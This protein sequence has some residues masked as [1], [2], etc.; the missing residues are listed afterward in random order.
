MHL[1]RLR[2][3]I[4]EAPNMDALPCSPSEQRVPVH[5]EVRCNAAG[6]PDE[7][8]EVRERVRQ[9]VAKLPIVEEGLLDISGSVRMH[10]ER[11]TGEGYEFST[12]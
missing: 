6:T 3:D 1:G 11:G 2:P 7:I 8:A 5:V 4:S 9:F 12:V 10:S